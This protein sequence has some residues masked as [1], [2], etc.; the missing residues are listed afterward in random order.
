MSPASMEIAK[1]L[2]PLVCYWFFNAAFFGFVA[3]QS[4]T[5]LP[6]KITHVLLF[7]VNYAAFI[8]FSMLQFNLMVNWTLIIALFAIE[9]RIAF[10]MPWSSALCYAI[11]GASTGLALTILAR[12]LF[13]LALDIPQSRLNNDTM[14]ESN[15]KA[16]PVAVGFAFGACAF[17]LT[18][19]YAKPDYLSVVC[20]NRQSRSFYL[21]MAACVFC[22]MCT[23]LLIYY[24]PDNAI[25]LKLW[26]IKAAL[27]ASFVLG[28]SLY[29]AYR[30]GYLIQC[31]QKS[32]R[33]SETIARHRK[34]NDVLS[35]LA[36]HDSLTG[37][38]TRAY[39]EGTMEE[40]QAAGKRFSLAFI[41]ID[42]LKL[43]NDTCGH[44]V[45]DDY[46]LTVTDVLSDFCHGNEGDRLFRYGGDEFV[47]LFPH[48]DTAHAQARL[49]EVAHRLRTENESDRFPFTVSIS[50]GVTEAIPGEPFAS[51]IERADANMYAHKRRNP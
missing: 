1:F 33:L 22:Y 17:Y 27:S 16:F 41:D 32:R 25:V 29:Y 23:V 9:I 18:N 6:K 11:T 31:G 3:R 21:I 42:N 24:I 49:E 4:A 20:D 12:S 28:L 14:E 43:A 46:I 19:R 2:V 36:T 34:E 48:L 35:A 51:T 13:S 45:G 40:L 10:K 47:A 7:V 26:G 38:Y 44:D 30:A 39:L 15:I 5:R 50:Y 37:C 8:V